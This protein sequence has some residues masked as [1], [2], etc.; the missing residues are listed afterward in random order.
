M[1]AQ[2][3]KESPFSNLALTNAK[4]F[5]EALKTSN[6]ED[7]RRIFGRLARGTIS[8]NQSHLERLSHLDSQMS[9][10]YAQSEVCETNEPKKCYQ[11]SPYLERLMQTEKNYERLVWAWKGWHDNA[12]NAIRSQYLEMVDLRNENCRENGY[13]DLS[14]GERRSRK[15]VQ[16]L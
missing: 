7:L 11:L 15:F 14:V 13:K 5:N 10:T 1:T 6:D 2:G 3:L 8:H 9:S 12:G 16:R 4:K